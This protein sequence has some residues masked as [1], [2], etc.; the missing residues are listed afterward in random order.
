MLIRFSKLIAAISVAIFL[1]SIPAK[2]GDAATLNVLGFSKD[3]NVFA[4]E[5]YGIQDGS[6]FPYANRFY[7][8]VTTD[9]YLRGSPVRFR[10]DDENADI[11]NAREQAKVLGDAI[12]P[13]V[14]LEPAFAAAVNTIT[15]TNNDRH[16]LA[17][18]P[19]AIFPPI[20]DE[21]EFE[22][23]EIPFGP[24]PSC[25]AVV[26]KLIGFKLVK[27]ATLSNEVAQLLNQDLTVPSSRGCPTGYLLGGIYTY[28][29]DDANLI[30]AVM[31]G[32]ETFGFEGPDHRWLAVTAKYEINKVE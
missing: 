32:V 3:G 2:A 23:T 19:R 10:I 24:T 20:D 15:Q 5:E 12:F 26:D 28:F 29:V 7:I 8:D 22:L 1:G 13:Q 25:E 30:Y 6:G 16:R 31:I 21:L 14:D 17:A 9:K 11:E 27:V 18:L 4:F